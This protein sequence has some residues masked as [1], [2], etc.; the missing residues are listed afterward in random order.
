M[1]VDNEKKLMT[2]LVGDGVWK[3]MWKGWRELHLSNGDKKPWG[4]EEFSF[5]EGKDLRK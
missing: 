4:E 1:D 3:G 2:N 5:L